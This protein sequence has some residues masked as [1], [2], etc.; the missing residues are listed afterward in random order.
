MGV[1]SIFCFSVISFGTALVFQTQTNFDIVTE[2]RV[3]NA[4]K[5]IQNLSLMQCADS[6]VR[7]AKKDGCKVAGYN[8]GSRECHLSGL[9]L[10]AAVE[11][12]TAEWKILM[13]EKG[14]GGL[15]S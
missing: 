10:D 15:V 11:N 14:T 1:F 7:L 2:T 12:A 6:C 4:S 3:V 9:M 8:S 5:I 13:P